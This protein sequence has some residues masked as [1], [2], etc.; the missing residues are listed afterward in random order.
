[1]EYVTLGPTGMNVSQLCFGTW[2]FGHESDGVVETSEEKAHELLDAAYDR[3]VNFIDTSNNYGGGD[4]ERYIGEW[5]DDHD[6]EEFVLASKVFYTA[7]SRFDR[8]LSPKTI[9]AEIEGTLDRLGT[10]YL[11]IYYI[12]RFDDD[13]PISATLS[14]LDDLVRQGKV[15]HIGVSTNRVRNAAGR[16]LTE[17]LWES[18]VGNYESFAVTQPKLNAAHR[19]SA[20]DFLEVCAKHGLAVCPYEPLEGGFLTGKYDRETPPSGSRGDLNDWAADRFDDRQW[21]VLEQV[22]EVASELDATPAQVA[23]RWLVQQDGFTCVPITGARTVDQLEENLGALDLSLSSDQHDR[24]T[25][26]Y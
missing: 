21:R 16:K 24:I 20:A 14:A 23:L 3:G 1:M 10:E 25:E 8:N 12:H 11:D 9:H 7:R 4:S 6:R 2:R 18:D 15:R 17:A 13:T 26:A 22:T 19:D 5:L